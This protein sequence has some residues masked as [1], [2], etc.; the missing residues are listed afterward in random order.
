MI[1]GSTQSAKLLQATSRP[2]PAEKI[3]LYMGYWRTLDL[4]PK[5]ISIATRLVSPLEAINRNPSQ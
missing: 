5:K 4:T 2:V 1:K 3:I